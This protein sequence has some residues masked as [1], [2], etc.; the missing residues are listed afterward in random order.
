[1]QQGFEDLAIVDIRAVL[2][3][4]AGDVMIHVNEQAPGLVYSRSIG[5]V[6]GLRCLQKRKDKIA[7]RLRNTLALL[8]MARLRLVSDAAFVPYHLDKVAWCVGYYE[9]VSFG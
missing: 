8:S 9:G 5:L 3:K 2:W 6:W 4:S 7:F 1:M